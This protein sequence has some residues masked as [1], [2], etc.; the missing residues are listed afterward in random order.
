MPGGWRTNGYAVF[1]RQCRRQRFW[2]RSVT[3]TVIEPTGVARRELCAVLEASPFCTVAA[4][5]HA[6]PGER[7]WT[8]GS[9]D[10][11]PVVRAKIGNRSWKVCLDRRHW[12]TGQKAAYT[13]VAAGDVHGEVSFVLPE[14]DMRQGVM[15][16]RV[17]AWLPKQSANE[18]MPPRLRGRARQ[19]S[20]GVAEIETADIGALRE[21]V[22]ANLVSFPSQVP[23]FPGH[24]KPGIQARLVQLYFVRGWNCAD[25]GKRFNLSSTHVRNI[26]CLWKNRAA[27]AHFVQLIPPAEPI[28][29]DA[30]AI[31]TPRT[32]TTVAAPTLVPGSF[33]TP[34][35][36][37]DGTPQYHS[38]P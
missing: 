26:L 10:G 35:Q 6:A 22:R 38:I 15:T 14:D 31:G 3:M 20:R 23:A 8:V 32:V 5:V 17:T 2:L 24:G 4:A 30:F 28:S 33:H 18:V 16:C 37:L 9:E 7:V 1:C 13:K 21:A 34:L 29:M 36:R 27:R 25:I 11:R 12:T 19:I